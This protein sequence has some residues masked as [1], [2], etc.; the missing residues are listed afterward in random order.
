MTFPHQILLPFMPKCSESIKSTLNC[1]LQGRTI[2]L[3]TKK[4]VLNNQELKADLAVVISFQCGE[5]ST[6]IVDTLYKD[7]SR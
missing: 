4:H 2:I 6:S 3:N 5:T 1:N 7:L